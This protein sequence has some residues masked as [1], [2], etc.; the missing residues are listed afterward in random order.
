MALADLSNVLNIFRERELNA[1]VQ[2]TLFKEVLLMTL[3]RASSAD[4]N[5]DPVEVT[6]VQEIMKRVT[7]EEVTEA[8]IRLA[9]RP[10]LFEDAP[11][12]KYLTSV[13]KRI[14]STQRAGVVCS[15]AEVIKSDT[16]VSVLE[17]DFFNMVAR[18]LQATPA[19]IAGL[20]AG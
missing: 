10:A 19:E 6:T 3:A 11:F 13:R 16:K 2:E 4:A 5:I 12:G 8:D 17:I 9:S 7:G 1:E 14:S 18:E 20:T 15:L